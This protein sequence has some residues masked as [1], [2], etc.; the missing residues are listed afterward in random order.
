MMRFAMGWLG[1]ILLHFTYPISAAL[2]PYV[3]K[4]A[5]PAW[6]QNPDLRAGINVQGGKIVHPALQSL[7]N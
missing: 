4:L 3:L 2:I 7:T 1:I 5:E 6:E